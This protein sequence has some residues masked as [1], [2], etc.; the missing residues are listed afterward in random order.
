[1]F[2]SRCQK[3]TYSKRCGISAFRIFGLRKLMRT[4][5]SESCRN[6]SNTFG[7]SMEKENEGRIKGFF[8][9]MMPL[10]Y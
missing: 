8:V 1:M 9:M 2:I 3:V 7:N 10:Y 6:R 4:V 5:K